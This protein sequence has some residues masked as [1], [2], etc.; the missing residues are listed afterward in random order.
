MS[1]CCGKTEGNLEAVI[2]QPLEGC[3]CTNL[4]RGQLA[5]NPIG[6]QTR[7]PYHGNSYWKPVPEAFE[8]DVAVY[9]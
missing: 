4:Q 9:P 3:Q 6:A 8:A 2:D 1:A 5:G 7:F